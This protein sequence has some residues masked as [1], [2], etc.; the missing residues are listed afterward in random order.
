MRTEEIRR[1]IISNVR[2]HPRDIARLT[3]EHFDITRQSVNQH[4]QRMVED[5]TLAAEGHTRGHTYRL[6]PAVQWTKSYLLDDSL[7]ED[8]VWREDIQP[9]LDALP[10]NAAHI[11]IYG[12]T[13][14]F[15]NAID[16]SEGRRIQVVVHKDAA[17][18]EMAVI[19]DGKGIFSKIQPQLNLPD[20]RHAVLELAKG[21]LTTDPA[22]H[23]GEDIYFISR[24]F[25]D[26][27][28]FS[29]GVS[30]SNDL[31]DMEA[32]LLEKVCSA[33][34]TAVWMRLDNHTSRTLTGMLDRF[35]SRK[36][37][38]FNK[39][40]IPVRLVENGSNPVSRARAKRVLA[41]AEQFKKVVLDFKEV[42]NIGPTFADEIFRVFAKQYPDIEII[43]V[44]ANPSVSRMI[45]RAVLHKGRP[46]RLVDAPPPEERPEDPDA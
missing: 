17:F 29:H 3:A 27:N 10:E 11:W 46:A 34:G 44:N 9:L 38:G 19:D 37:F 5:E 14:I 25:D 45:E 8:T 41:R 6:A 32:W 12:F 39:T 24:L 20:E 31:E 15:N 36:E 26:F 2:E 23:T 16:H 4:L 22:N 33:K 7:F 35:T 42:A 30:Y 21:K 18:T 13:G 1:F 28:I 40:V 43:H